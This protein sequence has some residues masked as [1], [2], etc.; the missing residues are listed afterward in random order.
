MIFEKTQL[1]DIKS[2]VDYFEFYKQYMPDLQIRGRNAWAVCKM[3]RDTKPSLQVN[4][5]TGTFRCWG[6]NLYGDIFTF[7]KEFFN[8]TFEQSVRTIAEMYNVELEISDEERKINE[9]RKMLYNVNKIMADKFKENLH[10]NLD[11]WNYLTKVRGLSPK[12][13]EKFKLGLGIKYLPEKEGLKKVGLLV[14]SENN[15]W[16]SKFRDDR[17]IFPRFDEYGNIVSFTG[18][19]FVEKE[20]AKYMHT[21]NTKIYNKSE[22]LFGLYFSKKYIKQYNSV[23]ITEGNIDFL[24]LY[25]KG[26]L[27]SVAL[28]GLNISDTQINLLKKYTS[29]FYIVVEDKAMI[30]INKTNTTPL[31]KLYNKIIE[32]IP[33]ATVYIIDLRDKNGEKCDPDMY[34]STHSGKDFENLI[35]NAK[36]YNEYIINSK[37]TKVNPKNIEEKTAYINYLIPRLANIQSF[38]TRKQYIELVSNKLLIPENDIYRKV[39]IYVEKQDKQALYNITYDSRPVFIQ[40]MLLSMCFAPNFDNHSIMNSIILL[41]KEYLEPFYKNIL[42]NI[43][44]PYIDKN[45]NNKPI[46]FTVFFSDVLYNENIED[47][48]RKTILDIYLKTEQLE[49]FT[50]NDVE[51]LLKEQINILKTYKYNEASIGKELEILDI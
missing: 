5:D 3:H 46:D 42:I 38:L 11:A 6:C 22:N 4:L 1:Q 25:Q 15:E 24:K 16:Y 26:I 2:K 23:I 47:L 20:S 30:T 41:A 29:K 10:S 13:I 51:E 14:Q 8:V 45:K 40:K 32:N 27:N 35:Q 18:R 21:S 49:D 17:V 12:I 50:Q 48:E 7:Y 9:E 43:I 33:Y 31:E 44:K 36:V 19:L 34:L 37:L 28:D 39:K